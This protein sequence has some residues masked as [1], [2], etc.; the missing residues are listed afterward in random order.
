LHRRSTRDSPPTAYVLDTEARLFV[1]VAGGGDMDYSDGDATEGALR[2]LMQRASDRS[3]HSPEMATGMVDWASRYHLSPRRANLLRPFDHLLRGHTLEVGSGC[4]V[5]T[6]FLGELGGEVVALEA[7]RRRA[8]ITAARCRGLDNVSVYHERLERFE[9]GR[10]FSA[11]TLVGVLEW[12]SRFADGEEGVRQVLDHA[13]RLLDDDGV[14]IIAI[15]NQLGLKYFAG[16]PE[17]HLGVAMSGVSDIYRPGEPRTF[18]RRDLGTLVTAAGLPHQAVYAVLPD[19][20]FPRVMVSP[21][22]LD[23]PA[24]SDD[25][26]A[27]A[28]A[29]PVT[30]PQTPALP[31]FSLEQA[32]GLVAR[33]GLL[34]DLSNSLIVVAG[35]TS[36]K[37]D[38]GN[39]P[40]AWHFTGDRRPQF[41]RETRFRR[42]PRGIV[43]EH[44]ALAPESS[45]NPPSDEALRHRKASDEF[46]PGEVWTT[47]LGPILNR[48]G[49]TIEAVAAWAEPW[50]DALAKA[51]GL[52]RPA[53]AAHVPSRLVDATP[54]NM[55]HADGQFRFFDLE[56]EL[57]WRVEFGFAL[58]RGLFWSLSRFQ[59]VAEPAEGLPTRVAD[60][61]SLVAAALGTPLTPSDESRYLDIEADLQHE[62]AAVPPARARENLSRLRMWP[63]ASL[64][65]LAGLAAQVESLR[66]VTRQMSTS[67]DDLRREVDRYQSA[68]QQAIER[69]D[70]EREEAERERAEA[71]RRLDEAARAHAQALS[72]QSALRAAIQ[73]QLDQLEKAHRST[74]AALRNANDEHEQTRNDLRQAEE[75]A[76]TL[77]GQFQRAEHLAREQA[78]QLRARQ[79][80]ARQERTDSEERERQVRAA[81]ARAIPDARPVRRSPVSR[82]LERLREAHLHPRAIARHPIASAA[83]L[84]R[85]TS[86]AYRAQIALVADSLLFDAA[87]YGAVTGL[88]PGP[89]M[90]AHFFRVGDVADQ[91]PHPLFDAPW[92][93]Q[94]NPD[95][96]ATDGAL[97]HYVRHGGWELRNP[98]PLFDARHYLAQWPGDAVRAATPLSH[99]LRVGF[100]GAAAPHPLFDAAY[101]LSQRP[102]LAGAR[103]NPLVHY[104]AT[105]A[106]ELVDPHPLFS[107]RYYLETN[108]DIGRANPLD[109][110]VR[111]GAIEGRSPHP[112]FNIGYY[113]QQRPDVHAQG[114]NAL[115]HYLDHAGKEDVDPHPLFDTRFYLGQ[116]DG[117]CESGIDPVA[118]FLRWGWRDGLRPNPWFDPVWYLERNP[119]VAGV[120]P[121]LHFMN[122]GWKEGRDP[123]PEFSVS[124]YLA[125]HA[126]VAD[127][128]MN[129]LEH[130]IRYGLADGHAVER[131]AQATLRPIRTRIDVVGR[132]EAAGTVMCV[133][134]V[135][136]WPVGAGNE[137]AL[138]RLL[139]HF[140]RRG[141]RILLVLAP[142]PGQPLA[143]GAFEHLATEFGN[144]VVCDR[145]GRVEFR[146]RDFPDVLSR[147]GDDPAALLVPAE[148]GPDLDYC[149][150]VV[151]AVV[152]KLADSIGNVAILA[153][154]IFMTRFFPLMGPNVLRIVH[155]HDVL[156]QKES[157][158]L[159]YGLS[160]MQ[161]SAADEARLL[162]R[163][164]V[165]MAVHEGDAAAL[166]R[167][168]PRREI[169][170]VGV[171]ADVRSN[172]EWPSR[173]VAFL[174]GS[175]NQMNLA[176]LRDFLRFAWPRV[177]AAV[178]GAELRVAGAVGQAVPP[179]TPGVTVLG[180][181][182]D[183]GPEYATARVVINPAVAGTGLKIKSIEALASLTPVVG[184][185]HNR[186]GLSEALTPWVHE[187][188]DWH[189]FANKTIDQL[190]QSRSPFDAVAITAIA[191]QLS[192]A[193][194]YGGLDAR[195]DRFMAEAG[196]QQETPRP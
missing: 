141:Y 90:L 149:P 152:R 57:P 5:L 1:P 39:A 91:S 166:R 34:G 188:T 146:L 185:P 26:A 23:D 154:Y 178:P 155:T 16:W 110:F 120:N 14:L 182:A 194:A 165:V 161:I 43:I 116:V 15:E 124:A 187:A 67:R 4:G 159:A 48:P 72:K 105:A 114:V 160:D 128:G 44:R 150:D 106:T 81:A 6:R 28:A 153:Q 20:K 45:V 136:P 87:H 3:L 192:A 167:L 170:V 11:I 55:V 130:F 134:H 96:P 176:G 74:A 47:R 13:A 32:L 71:A 42:T 19:Y 189:D 85:L 68:L 196:A 88:P 99:F 84:A 126:D 8:E 83:G 117:L 108:P 119:D 173:P 58:F 147:L 184:W 24:W 107:T 104:L 69:S 54:F 156:S 52:H 22:G 53:A 46:L 98:H 73:A 40:L 190:R 50:R 18:G 75:R 157:N 137:Y 135:S 133:G 89:D 142:L 140:Q 78:R 93:R 2:A 131:A 80:A 86:Q 7:S 82:S 100:L 186:D 97:M 63:R 111:H 122:S 118:H 21:A 181:V 49:W 10:R 164:D 125:R 115:L 102:D 169:V 158:V 27:M 103:A 168:A 12:A 132:A 195:V 171:D 151:A 51:A 145:S 65:T 76:A 148:P 38:A 59:S 36:T 127:A 64:E 143:P 60:L 121:L 139:P 37:A 66:E 35:R 177:R 179:G 9:T 61:C 94:Q 79:R 129:P 144:V 70:A 175:G 92:Y 25:L 56:W 29:T 101:Y 172:R 113:W 95:I 109:H 174:P 163:G 33:N 183:L 191:R 112:L 31:L 180:R 30:D 41:L 138:S 193:N 77:T 162:N 123:S 62:V 17:D